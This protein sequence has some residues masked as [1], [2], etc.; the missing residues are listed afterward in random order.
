[1][2]PETSQAKH[3]SR[4]ICPSVLYFFQFTVLSSNRRKPRN[5]KDVT[6]EKNVGETYSNLFRQDAAESEK[7][8]AEL[9]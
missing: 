9:C 7:L 6:P 2:M 4:A 5:A 1:M 8:N 3:A